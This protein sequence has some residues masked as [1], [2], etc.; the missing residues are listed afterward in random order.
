MSVGAVTLQKMITIDEN[1]DIKPPSLEQLQDKDILTLWTRDRSF[2]RQKYMQEAGVIYYMG[3]PTSP[4]RQRGLSDRE[5]LKEAIINYN[6]PTS[7]EPDTLVRRLIDRYYIDCITEA[8][9]A[10]EVLQQSVHLVAV[11]ATK[12]NEHLN[13]K[14]ND[15]IDETGIAAMLTMM[16]A[17][18]KRVVEIPGLTKALASAYE[19]LR[20]EE[21]DTMARGKTKV[22]SSM[23][24][25]G[26]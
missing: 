20:N 16:D 21:Q 12:I 6:L 13:N 7:Y 26:R 8:G 11:A 19:N 25:R 10:L 14:I 15:P 1:G 22:T 3:C 18:S 17:I 2:Q 9:V 4:V 23:S 5:C 24:A